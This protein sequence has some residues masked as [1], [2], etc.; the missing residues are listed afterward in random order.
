MITYRLPLKQ[1]GA[2]ELTMPKCASER[3]RHLDYAKL[4]ELR[5]NVI[6]QCDVTIGVRRALGT[7]LG[8]QRGR[9]CSL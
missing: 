3:P 9:K 2:R 5:S 1:I 6:E 7:R 4:F 8:P